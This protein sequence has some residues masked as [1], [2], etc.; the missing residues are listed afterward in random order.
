MPN[1]HLHPLSKINL[2][3]FIWKWNYYAAKL[4]W[5]KYYTSLKKLRMNWGRG[6]TNT[7]TEIHALDESI[8]ELIMLPACV[9]EFGAQSM[10]FVSFGALCFCKIRQS[11]KTHLWNTIFHKSVKSSYASFLNSG[12]TFWLLAAKICIWTHSFTLGRTFWK[13]HF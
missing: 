10:F 12:C 3:I 4:T 2:Q 8:E 6:N 9:I 11:T 13:S 7:N 5:G 1:H